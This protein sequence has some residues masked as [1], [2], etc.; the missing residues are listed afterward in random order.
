MQVR[1]ENSRY[2]AQAS[3]ESTLFNQC[4]QNDGVVSKEITSL[5]FWNHPDEERRDTQ[6]VLSAL[7]PPSKVV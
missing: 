7:Y 3:P 6:E 1:G 5:I 4:G 2:D